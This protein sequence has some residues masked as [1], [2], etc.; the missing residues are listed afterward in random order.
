MRLELHKAFIVEKQLPIFAIPVK[1]AFHSND[2][3][4]FDQDVKSVLLNF[5]V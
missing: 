1:V 3:E 5:K 4:R 2:Q